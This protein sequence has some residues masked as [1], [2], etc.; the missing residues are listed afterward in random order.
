MGS[1]K[2]TIAPI[3]A[4]TLGYAF[5]DIDEEIE[6]LTGKKISEIFDESG[7]EHFRE[8]ER[9]LLAQASA[10][11][12]CVVSLG[13]GTV[14]SEPNLKVVKDSGVL[15]YL[16]ADPELI[17]RRVKFKTDR[18]LLKSADGKPLSDDELRDTIRSLLAAREPFYSKADVIVAVD[19]R[20]VGLMIDEI[21]RS[22]KDMI[23]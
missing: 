12:G 6:K 10:R 20:T 22:I 17:Y 4:N 14:A 1:G 2:S 3:L 13:G 9:S 16:K 8:I 18:P 15:V 11:T 7:E 19:D 5:F 21:I 23:E